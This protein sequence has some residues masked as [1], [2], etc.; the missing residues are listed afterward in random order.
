VGAS[1]C[2]GSAKSTTTGGSHTTAGGG[3]SVIPILN[4][5]LP[6]GIDTLDATKANEGRLLAQLGLE[7]LMNYTPTGSLKP[8]LAKSVSHPTSTR[9][10]YQLRH[11]VK[12][13]DGNELTSADVVNALN[14]QR[15]PGSQVA[16]G[17]TSV[18][19]IK[20]AGRYKVVVDLL[21]PDPNW[22]FVSAENEALIWEKKF[23]DEHKSTFGQ[24]G[25][26]AVGTGPWKIDSLD[27]T[28]GATLSANPTWWNG[29]VP[30]NQIKVSFF[31]DENSMARAF[32]AGEIDIVPPGASGTGTST[33]IQ[34]PPA[35]KAI[36]SNATLVKSQTC[37][38][39]FATMN[40]NKA[41]WNDVHVRR[42]VAYALNPSA[43]VHANYGYGKPL[44]TLLDNDMLGQIGSPAQVQTL[45]NSLPKYPYSVA[46]AKAELAKS[47]YPHGF[48]TTFDVL[49]A[50]NLPLITQAVAGQLKAI[51][52]NVSVRVIPSAKF[53]AEMF[54]PPQG[55]PTT[56]YDF[57]CVGPDPDA[58]S[59]LIGS[60]N[61]KTGGLNFADYSTPT[62]DKLLA[63]AASSTDPAQR[64]TIYQKIL[65]IVGNDAPYAPFLNG[66]Y[67]AA[68]SDKFTFTVN[69][70]SYFNGT[71]ALDVK[72]K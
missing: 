57:G 46:Q 49:T 45:V 27:P 37:T 48:A 19:S 54:G 72:P 69:P 1:G 29:K 6:S 32:A 11:G 7:T 63:K 50:D 21:R 28:S 44:S 43:L 17:Y 56:V 22:P 2:G 40:V 36:A 4:V 62:V 5:P 3:S 16:Y 52:I 71:W 53:L 55:R 58:L 41:P 59:L 24:P 38:I 51:G 13:W 61:R 20:A 25:T 18:K 34:N 14:Y 35:F 23:Q 39:Y 68:V 42:A 33:P 12:F 15:R 10:V 66:A 65:T 8:W 60:S 31:S 64:R 47:A 26:L 30:I 9:Y 67:V 70:Y